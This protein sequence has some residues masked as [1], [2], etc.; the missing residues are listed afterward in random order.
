MILVRGT[1]RQPGKT[2]DRLTQTSQTAKKARANEARHEQGIMSCGVFS[3]EIRKFI[4]DYDGH[5]THLSEIEVKGTVTEKKTNR[6]KE[7]VD[8]SIRSSTIPK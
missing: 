4:Y 8:E 5:L 7:K 1:R 3:Y 2:R 6:K